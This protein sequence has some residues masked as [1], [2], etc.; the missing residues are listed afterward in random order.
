MLNDLKI[1]EIS[2]QIKTDEVFEALN[3]N[4]QSIAPI[5]SSHQSEWLNSIYS[6]FKDHDKFNEDFNVAR[7][8]GRFNLA[9]HVQDVFDDEYEVLPGYGAGGRSF[10]LTV[11]YK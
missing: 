11:I 9:M 4:Y 1:P 3:N 8:F 7:T 10:V 6:A 2:K 5:W